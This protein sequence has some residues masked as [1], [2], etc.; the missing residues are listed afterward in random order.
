VAVRVTDYK[1]GERASAPE[2]LVI[3]G[4]L[5]LQRVLYAVACQQLLQDTSAIRSRLVYLKESPEIISLARLGPA[6]ELVSKFVVAACAVLEAGKTVPGIGAESEHNNLR[7]ALPAS[8]GYFRRKGLNFRAAV[9]DLTR[10]WSA[11]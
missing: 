8:P 6:V 5:E 3:G 11:K 10:F 7:F 1:T 4:G 9:R 2:T